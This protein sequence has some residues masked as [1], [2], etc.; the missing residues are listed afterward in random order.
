MVDKGSD[1]ATFVTFVIF[2]VVQKIE[3]QNI[4]FKSRYS[5]DICDALATNELTRIMS[6][7]KLH[8]SSAYGAY[9]FPQSN[10][11]SPGLISLLF[12]IFLV[13][14]FS[15]S[16]SF[17]LFF[18][19]TFF[20]AFSFYFL[21]SFLLPSSKAYFNGWIFNNMIISFWHK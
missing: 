10:S 21:F 19:F 16:F 6:A 14:L 3:I 7:F 5:H 9:I 17:A 4:V 12:C 8:Y 1:F 15:F 18:S 13:F 11:I 2:C 20:F